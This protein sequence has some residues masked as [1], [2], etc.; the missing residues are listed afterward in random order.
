V[1]FMRLFLSGWQVHFEPRAPD[2][3]LRPYADTRTAIDNRFIVTEMAPPSKTWGHG[4][5]LGQ[6]DVP[7]VLI[8]KNR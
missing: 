2:R 8:R 6:P 4:K 3:T 5:N 7:Q 1:R